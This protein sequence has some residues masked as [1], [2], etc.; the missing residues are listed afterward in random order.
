MDTRT[1]VEAFRERI[2]KVPPVVQSGNFKC[3]VMASRTIVV[4]QGRTVPASGGVSAVAAP[5]DQV[6]SLGGEALCHHKG[7]EGDP[8]AVAEFREHRGVPRSTSLSTS[9]I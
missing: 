8:V 1:V 2:P 7:E 5:M 9:R 4:V 6:E 3:L